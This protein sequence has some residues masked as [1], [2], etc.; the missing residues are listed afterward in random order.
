ME[1]E[2]EQLKEDRKKD[3]GT[4]EKRGELIRERLMKKERLI[5]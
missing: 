5:G 2:I 4:N 3:G 1:D